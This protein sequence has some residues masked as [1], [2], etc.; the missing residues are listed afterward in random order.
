MISMVIG[1]AAVLLFWSWSVWDFRA[2]ASG[3]VGENF[4]V[5]HKISATADIRHELLH[6]KL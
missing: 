3:S 5:V 2:L 6:P 1:I 4:R